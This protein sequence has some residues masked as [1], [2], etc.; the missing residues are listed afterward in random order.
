MAI[1]KLGKLFFSLVSI[2]S[3]LTWAWDFLLRYSLFS[4]EI[5]AAIIAGEDSGDEEVVE[6]AI[7]LCKIDQ[8]DEIRE[9]RCDHLFH[10][11]CL[12]R[13]AGYRRSTCPICRLSLAPPQLVSGI[14][15]LLFKFCYFDD[16]G[17]RE[18]WWL[19]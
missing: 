16:S 14:Q 3:A 12:D 9:L 19:R 6:C 7:C 1:D 2:V 17:H 18:T 15:V 11:V 5:P 4:C 10:K 8:D 13:W